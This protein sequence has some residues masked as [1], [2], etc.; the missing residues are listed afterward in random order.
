MADD[1]VDRD[2]PRAPRGFFQRGLM[3][4]DVERCC[5][6][7]FEPADE[8]HRRSVHPENAQQEGEIALTS[9]NWITAQVNTA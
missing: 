2:R 8:E 1:L 9:G 4:G 7:R 3:G 5:S 6:P